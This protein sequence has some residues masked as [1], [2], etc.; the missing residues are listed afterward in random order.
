MSTYAAFV[1]GLCIAFV[2][3]GGGHYALDRRVGKEF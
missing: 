1:A 3:R 2:M